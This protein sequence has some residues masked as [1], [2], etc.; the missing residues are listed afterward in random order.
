MN[1]LTFRLIF[2]IIFSCL[3]SLTIKSTCNCTLDVNSLKKEI[4]E[5][6]E[7]S[8]GI[9]YAYPVVKDTMPE[10]PPGYHPIMINHYGRHGSRWCIKEY[11]YPLLL[12]IMQQALD[13][14]NLTPIGIDVMRQV[15]AL[16][17]HASGKAGALSPLGEKQHRAIAT[18]LF[19]R[20][21]QLFLSTDTIMAIS[22]IEP[23][24]II[25]MAAFC[26]ALKEHSPKLIINRSAYPG[27]MDFISYSSPEAKLNCSDT[28]AWRNDFISF[29]DSVI[30]PQ[31]LMN[32]I[33][34]NPTAIQDA[35]L[36]MRTLHDIAVDI[37]DVE[38][39]ENLLSLFTPEE[40][41]NLWTV[42][43]YNMYVKHC[44]ANVSK[45]SGPKSA[46]S[47][48]QHFID[49]T[50]STL[51][52]PTTSKVILRFGH[53]TVLIRLMALMG[54]CGMAESQANPL[55]Y[56]TAWQ[57]FRA[58]PMAANLQMII[59]LHESEEPLIVLRHNESP[60]SLPLTHIEG[61]PFLYP[62]REVRQLWIDRI[63]TAYNL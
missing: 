21:P 27:D 8:G 44:Y 38:R 25:S 37:Q 22:S 47:L 5:T 49:T 34:R 46:A 13:N 11:E 56:M 59:Y 14:D 36:F 51:H 3:C 61:F 26:E 40:L 28:A 15:E 43:N 42:L 17:L 60:V 35:G 62:W 41:Y 53:D 33:F 58:A 10:I 23:R 48:L 19:K 9:Y 52:F 39:T 6:P 12:D 1:N 50:D 32:V 57:D 31:R 20:F 2:I 4:A 18:R 54:I 16:Y 7:K 30:N 63:A 24:C 29:R 55:Q 45:G